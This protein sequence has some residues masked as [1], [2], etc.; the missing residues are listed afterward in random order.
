MAEKHFKKYST[1]L[2]IRE[3]QMKYILTFYLPLSEWLLSITSKSSCCPG[4][5]VKK[6]FFIAD[7]SVNLYSH[8]GN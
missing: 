1:H 7:K 3:M 4:W 2:A 5:R 8:C 6:Q